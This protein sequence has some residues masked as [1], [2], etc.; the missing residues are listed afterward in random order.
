[1]ADDMLFY[2]FPFDGANSLMIVI[3]IFTAIVVI[4]SFFF[5]GD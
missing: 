5:E 1:M 4:R 2:E 3:L